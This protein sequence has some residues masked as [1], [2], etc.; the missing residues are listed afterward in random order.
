MKKYIL[1][2]MLMLATVFIAFTMLGN[3][4]EAA[5][6]KTETSKVTGLNQNYV[7]KVFDADYYVQQNPDLASLAGNYEALLKHYTESGMLEGRQGSS[8]FDLAAY[9]TYNPDLVAAYQGNYELYIE[10]YVKSG[11][12]EGRKAIEDVPFNYTGVE[13]TEGIYGGIR[14]NMTPAERLSI[15][16][17][18]GVIEDDGVGGHIVTYYYYYFNDLEFDANIT[19]LGNTAL[20]NCINNDPLGAIEYNTEWI[21]DN[22]YMGQSQESVLDISEYANI[23]KI[24]LKDWEYSNYYAYGSFTSKEEHD[25]DWNARMEYAENNPIIWM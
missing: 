19:A 13:L 15:L 11:K 10:H 8:E 7:A 3:T 12:A 9:M 6:N 5:Q 22:C 14:H 1:K 23:E 2:N 4:A 20:N 18:G 24:T 16:S 17:K 21:P 25:A